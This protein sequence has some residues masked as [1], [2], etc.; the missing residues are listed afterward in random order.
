MAKFQSV[1]MTL[2]FQMSTKRGSNQL[3][4]GA[5]PDLSSSAVIPQI[6]GARFFF[7]FRIAADISSAIG[8]LESTEGSGSYGHQDWIEWWSRVVELLWEM[9]FPSVE[10]VRF[11]AEW[12][13][14]FGSHRRQL[15][16]SPTC[17][18]AD[19]TVEHCTVSSAIRMFCLVC[20]A[21][22]PG[23]LISS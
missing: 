20:Y 22:V 1:G 6:P 17:E 7:S 3:M 13:S 9:V 8:G 21:T 23:G 11:I 14:V 18:G 2:Y 15:G 19:G 12:C 16:C 4:M 5:P 10:L